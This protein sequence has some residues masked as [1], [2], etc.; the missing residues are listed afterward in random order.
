MTDTS[1]TASPPAPLALTVISA[2]ASDVFGED[3]SSRA[4]A[5]RIRA[6]GAHAR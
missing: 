2:S 4:F 1:S 3:P 6:I 5:A